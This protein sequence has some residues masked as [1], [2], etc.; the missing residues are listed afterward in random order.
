MRVV[1]THMKALEWQVH[2]SVLIERA[3]E[4]RNECLNLKLE[5]AKSNILGLSVSNPKFS[6]I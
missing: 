4:V 5:W 2:E 3:S 6:R 1:G